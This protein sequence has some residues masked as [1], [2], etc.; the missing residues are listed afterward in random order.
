MANGMM[1]SRG[2][3]IHPKKC[4]F[5]WN[6]LLVVS[7]CVVVVKS[8]VGAAVC[9]ILVNTC[10]YPKIIINYP[11]MFS[12]RPNIWVFHDTKNPAQPP[13]PGAA[14]PSADAATR[15]E[16][17]QVG[18]FRHPGTDLPVGGFG[19]LGWWG[20]GVVPSNHYWLIK[21]Y[22]AINPL[23]QILEE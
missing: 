1:L 11:G 23:C 10:F 2:K 4:A 7:A 9:N 19:M 22:E 20:G 3:N 21:T 8:F 14:P 6:M 13:A 18:T 17:N 5:S 12:P 16:E 15:R